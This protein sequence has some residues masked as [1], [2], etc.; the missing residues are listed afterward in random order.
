MKPCSQEINLTSDQ[1]SDEWRSPK[2][3][4]EILSSTG[5]AHQVI[6]INYQIISTRRTRIMLYERQPM[7]DRFLD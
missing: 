3:M 4:R 6:M 2:I 5:R 1:A 7:R